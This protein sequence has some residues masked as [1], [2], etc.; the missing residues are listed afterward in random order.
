M[1]V[2]KP[3]VLDFVE[4]EVGHPQLLER[5][6]HAALIERA[7]IL[8]L[9]MEPVELRV[10]D[11]DEREVEPRDELAAL[12]RQVDADRLRRL[13]P[14]DVVAAEAAVAR[15]DALPEVELL[16]VRVHLREASLRL[17]QRHQVAQVVE[18]HGIGLRLRRRAPAPAVPAGPVSVVR[19]VATSATCGSVSRRSGM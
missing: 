2:R 11:V 8:Q 10:L 14:L 9:L 16:G 15:D 4:V 7:R 19:Y 18:Q 1:A 6:Q 13:E 5:L 3:L 12:F 17:G